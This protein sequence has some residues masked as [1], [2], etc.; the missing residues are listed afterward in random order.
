MKR[1]E[2]Y[3][4]YIRGLRDGV[5]GQISSFDKGWNSAFKMFLGI[6]DKEE[7]KIIEDLIKKEVK[8]ETRKR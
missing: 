5:K 1:D 8:N 7:Q 4:V 2:A 6:T 3:R